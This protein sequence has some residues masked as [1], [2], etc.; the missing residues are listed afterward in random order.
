MLS[1]LV[2]VFCVN[3]SGPILAEF[4]AALADVEPGPVNNAIPLLG[5]DGIEKTADGS[6]TFAGAVAIPAI[7]GRDN[8]VGVAVT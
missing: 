1:L 3:S 4:D 5:I 6:C 2:L 8:S 7:T